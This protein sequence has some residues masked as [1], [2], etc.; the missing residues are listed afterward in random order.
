MAPAM[1]LRFLCLCLWSA[2]CGRLGY[3]EAMLNSAA[4]SGDDGRDAGLLPSDARPDYDAAPSCSPL[5]A[6]SYCE[7]LPELPEP[8]VLDGVLDC[9]PTLINF[10][11][12][13]WTASE[14]IPSDHSA[15]YAVA[16]REDGL[17]FYVEVDD[18]LRLP[19]LARDEGPWCGDGIE[20]YVDADGSFPAAPN[21]D[22]PG[23]IQLLAGAPARDANHELAA[24]ARFHTRSQLRAGEWAAAGH[25][26][27]IRDNGYALEAFVTAAELELRGWKLAQGGAVGINLAIDVSVASE[28][29]AGDCG[30]RLGQYFLHL[31]RTPCLFDACRPYQDISTFCTPRLE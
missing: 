17:Y 22:D 6:R 10:N 15:R 3:S 8:P 7:A 5:P 23:T 20:L 24:D 18:P 19:A 28:N 16:W 13:G 9:G 30:Q 31:T 14:P 21:Y 25:V 12:R 29:D 27:R 2:A 26:T 4:G 11:A 1:K